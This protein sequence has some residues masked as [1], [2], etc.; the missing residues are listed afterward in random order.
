MTPTAT[1]QQRK[2]APAN[3]KK[4]L[5]TATII[6]TFGGLL[7]GYDTGVINGALPFMQGTWA[8]RRSPKGW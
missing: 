1:A 8:S 2:T 3:H 5:R 7:F 4:A 6:S